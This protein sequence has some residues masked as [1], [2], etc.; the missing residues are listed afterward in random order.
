MMMK[1]RTDALLTLSAM[2]LLG[3]AGAAFGDASYQINT[4]SLLY[5]G[6]GAEQPC[7]GY[8]TPSMSSPVSW[9]GEYCC[10]DPEGGCISNYCT[11]IPRSVGGGAMSVGAGQFS[12][13]FWTETGPTCNQ[14][15]LKSIMRG[16]GAMT[17]DDVVFV[18]E[19]NQN[20]NVQLRLRLR[21]QILDGGQHSVSFSVANGGSWSI[22][23]VAPPASYQDGV[24]QY[25][26]TQPIQVTTN[27]P[28][29]WTMGAGFDNGTPG[30]CCTLQTSS[31]SMIISFPPSTIG[32]DGFQPVFIVPEGVTVMS[33][34]AGIND[35]AWTPP[36]APCATDFDNDGLTGASDLAT[37]LS[38][39]GDCS[40]CA[41][42]LTGDDAID[43][44][45]LATLLAA[46]G[47]CAG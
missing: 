7:G 41:A 32:P 34:Q 3:F 18:S 19:T 37:L 39:W 29:T 31:A 35:N 30:A 20:I 38:S 23:S 12:F 40:G 24:D 36:A 45:D 22:N 25:Y 42:D 11:S 44:G 14:T 33:A 5:G 6:P 4:A 17:F 16:S 15:S 47:P 2:T 27:Q 46:W 26:V 1:Q 28:T 8:S 10:P 21:G 9:Q 13:D 43:A